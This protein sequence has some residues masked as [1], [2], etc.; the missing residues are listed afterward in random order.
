[1][2]R[3]SISSVFDPNKTPVPVMDVSNLRKFVNLPCPKDI[4]IHT[5]VT[6]GEKTS[7]LD[8]P[9]YRVFLKE[10]DEFLMAAKK[11]TKNKTS[12][13][14]ITTESN[15]VIEKHGK[16]TVGKLRSNFM[17][18]EFILYDSGKNPKSEAKSTIRKE[19]AAISYEVNVM[20]S[21][22]PRRMTC[23]LPKVNQHGLLECFQ[24]LVSGLLESYSSGQLRRLEVLLNR[25]PK[26]NDDIAAYVLNFGGRV[27]MAS[28]KNFQLV[29]I[30]DDDHIILQ[31][32]RVGEQKF[33]MDFTHP[34]TPLQAF[35]ICLSSLDFKIACE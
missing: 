4:T 11:R 12:N 25:K 26:W 28:V 2:E 18:T 19:L 9:T 5:Y 3:E 13:Y 1:L 10:N 35:G 33:T 7:F 16:A 29:R 30:S 15:I 21:R 31:F 14:I 8:N 23:I 6:R 17:G 24:S 27:T 22:G 20:G 32:G 34:L